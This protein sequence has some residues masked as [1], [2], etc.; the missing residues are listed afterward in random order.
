METD[1]T[2]LN[3]V[4]PYSL[5]DADGWSESSAGQR[6]LTQVLEQISGDVVVVDQRV[7][8]RRRPWLVAVAAAVAVVVAVAIPVVILG[9]SSQGDAPGSGDSFGGGTV[10]LGVGH[11]WPAESRQV[12]PEGLASA[13]AAEV[14]GW[15]DVTTTIDSGSDPSGPVWVTIQRS[16]LAKLE[17]LT[18]PIP[19]GGRVLYQVGG[20]LSVRAVEPGQAMGW[21]IDLAQP[22]G[23]VAADL[24]IRTVNTTV[25]L[26]AGAAELL[27][28]YIETTEDVDPQQI[29]AVLVRYRNADGEV[30]AAAGGTFGAE[31]E[32]TKLTVEETQQIPSWVNQLGLNQFDPAVWRDRFDRMCGEGVWNPEVALALSSEFIASDLDA[33]AS[34]R[35]A[36][37]GPPLAED[38][39]VALWLMAVNTC[40]NRF[41]EGAIE[42]GLP[43]FSSVGTPGSS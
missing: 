5:D 4:N 41:P 23:A 32:P 12:S 1:H 17:V 26:N 16:G 2:I 18:A 38:G 36:D 7:K 29:E 19:E 37:L 20:R 6:T 24:T 35:G 9:R 3:D 25:A 22:N 10:R 27:Q 14:L 15:I 34:V 28:G 42:Q 11:V 21:R 31:P 8:H 33:G 30:V 43:S 13:F 40:R 39:A